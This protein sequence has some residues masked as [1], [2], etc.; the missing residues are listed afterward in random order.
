M[1]ST[2]PQHNHIYLEYQGK[3]SLKYLQRLITRY[4]GQS[5]HLE[6]CNGTRE[7]NLAYFRK[8]ILAQF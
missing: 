6:E 8:K 3:I 7:Q 2:L 1:S 5:P 4:T